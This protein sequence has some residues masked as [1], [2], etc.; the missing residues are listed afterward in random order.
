V[1]RIVYIVKPSHTPFSPLLV[2]PLRELGERLQLA[3]LRRRYSAETV[4]ARAGV[5]RMT[6]YKV[7]KGDPTVSMGTY[8]NVLRVLGL[9]GDVDLLA[10]DD[11]LGRKLQDLELPVRKIAPAR[12]GAP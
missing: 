9:H 6:L 8:A 11:V 7:E 10:R 5:T 3:R 1:Y 2:K 12:K 4:A